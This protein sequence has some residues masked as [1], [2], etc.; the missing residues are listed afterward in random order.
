MKIIFLGTSSMVPTKER[1]HSGIFIKHKTEGILVDCG[2]GTQRQ[3]KYSNIKP[4]KITRI[5]ISHWHGD[6]VLGLPGLF[7]TLNNSEYEGTL[8]LYGPSEVKEKI[9]LMM[10]TFSFNIEFNFEIIRLVPGEIIN[11]TNFRIF[12]HELKHSVESYGFV[13]KKKNRRKIKLG[14]I[15][16]LGIPEGPLLGKLQ[17]NKKIKWQGKTISPKEATYTIQGK[18]VG[19]ITDTMLCNNCNKIAKDADLLISEAVYLSELEDKAKEYMHLTAKQAALVASRNNVKKLI[20]THFS[21]RYKSTE[22]LCDEAKIYFPNTDCAYDL[23]K[24]EL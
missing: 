8:K 18:K 1:N 19:I 6:H 10:E 24:I 12:A 13:L 9:K 17:N 11:A 23:M 15:K 3:L 7:Q 4:S 20:L 22:E 5:L 21:Q 2:E 16:K 14:Y